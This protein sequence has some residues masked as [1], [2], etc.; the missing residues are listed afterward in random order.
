VLFENYV[1]I[2]KLYR[3]IISPEDKSTSELYY[4]EKD[5]RDLT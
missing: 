2:Y 4:S 5:I 3:F 1:Y